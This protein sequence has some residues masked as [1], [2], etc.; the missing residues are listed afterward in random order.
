M[1]IKIILALI[2]LLVVFIFVARKRRTIVSVTRTFDA[3]VATVWKLWTEEQHIQQW[4]GPKGYTAPVIKH[5]FRVGGHYLISMRAPN[6]TVHYN[7]GVYKEIIEQQK[8]VTT[9][10]FA[11]EHG[12]AI[13]G[14]AVKMPGDWPDEILITT[15]FTEADGK[16]TVAICEEGI[17]LIMKLF[18]GM[19]WQQQFDKF[20]VLL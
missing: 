17:P 10:S 14:R 18:A 1:L 12:N 2:A 11:D 19:G 9:M 3:P 13:A 6:G 20:E 4:W 16:T 5:D 8:I 7:C 15:T